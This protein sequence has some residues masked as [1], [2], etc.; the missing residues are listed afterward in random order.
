M[1]HAI[2]SVSEEI[3]NHLTDWENVLK[4]SSARFNQ[5]VEDN[6]KGCHNH[7]TNRVE[8]V[9]ICPQLLEAVIA[10]TLDDMVL[11]ALRYQI[12]NNG[13]NGIDKYKAAGSFVNHF[14]RHL[15]IAGQSRRCHINSV[16][17]LLSVAE[18]NNK[19]K[20]FNIKKASPIDLKEIKF[21]IEKRQISS[22]SLF[23]LFKQIF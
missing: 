7:H 15:P 20:I 12:A 4:R 19:N 1:R 2:N 11:M 3:Y 6:Q 10:S 14:M 8:I 18:D 5:L 17:V 16:I 22:E 21:F 23:L 13:F 9:K